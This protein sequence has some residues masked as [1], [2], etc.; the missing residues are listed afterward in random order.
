MQKPHLE[1]QIIRIAYCERTLDLWKAVLSCKKLLTAPY[2]KAAKN[3]P[4]FKW[5]M[6]FQV[7]VRSFDNTY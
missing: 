6:S 2:L 7:S 5:D 3:G 1:E 4:S